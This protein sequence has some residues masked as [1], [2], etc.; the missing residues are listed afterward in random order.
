M[1]KWKYIENVANTLIDRNYSCCGIITGGRV[2]YEPLHDI[3]R[4]VRSYEG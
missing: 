4:K 2:P 3:E 1:V